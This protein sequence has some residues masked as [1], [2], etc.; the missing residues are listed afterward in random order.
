MNGKSDIPDALRE[1]I[2][3]LREGL[4]S[5]KSALSMVRFLRPIFSE[6]SLNTALFRDILR[7]IEGGGPYPDISYPTM[8][9]NE[10]ILFNDPE[11]FFTVRLFIWEPGQYDP[12]HD[13]SSWGVIGPVSGDLDVINYERVDDGAEA[14]YAVLRETGR[15]TIRPGENYYVLP[16][17]GGIHR[18]GNPSGETIVQVS[19]YGRPAVKRNFINGYDPDRNLVHPIYAPKTKKRILATEALRH[20]AGT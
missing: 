11:R 8:F 12:V 10:V 19:V 15:V 20:F 3:R 6:L 14:G 2:D 1:F 18:T 9:D 4:R 13:H 16:L 17:N 7:S 5:T